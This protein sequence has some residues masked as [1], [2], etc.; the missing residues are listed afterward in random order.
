MGAKLLKEHKMKKTILTTL[1]ILAIATTSI[2]AVTDSFTV[3]T[4]VAEIGNMKIVTTS[5][6]PTDNAFTGLTD[7]INLPVTSSGDKGTVAYMAT[8]SNKRTGYTVT[9]VATPMTSGTG[10][11]TSYIDYTVGCGTQSIVTKGALPAVVTGTAVDT[12]SSLTVLTGK[13]LPI[14][15]SVD[16]P[17]FAAAVSGSYTGTV[18]FTFTAT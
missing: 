17:T 3:T 13:S 18:T 11:S 9:M 15:L 8:I 10:A 7:F 5:G 4:T 12:I 6:V 16:G 14:N 1:L 2:F